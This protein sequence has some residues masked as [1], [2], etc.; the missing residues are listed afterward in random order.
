MKEH[1]ITIETHVVRAGEDYFVR[2]MYDGR[3]RLELGPTPDGDAA[4]DLAGV[5][6]RTARATIEFFLETQ[7]W[8]MKVP[9]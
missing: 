9:A 8:P 4:K 3:Q 2:V 5:I 1:T 6:A 7:Q